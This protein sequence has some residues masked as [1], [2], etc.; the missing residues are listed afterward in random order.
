[1]VRSCFLCRVLHW[2]RRVLLPFILFVLCLPL[3]L[4]RF[5][6]LFLLFHFAFLP[7]FPPFLF[8]PSPIGYPDKFSPLEAA[9][10][11]PPW[12]FL[13]RFALWLL[14][15]VLLPLAAWHKLDGADPLTAEVR[16]RVGVLCFLRFPF[17]YVLRLGDQSV[18]FSHRFSLF[19]FCLQ[20]CIC[21]RVFVCGLF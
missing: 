18:D 14:L 17:S 10:A 7:H 2:K 13:G 19:R 8:I 20:F 3:H 5:L 21:E 1:M 11:I 4:W 15:A 12:Q 9:S 16:N 6:S